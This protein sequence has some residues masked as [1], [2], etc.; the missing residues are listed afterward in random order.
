MRGIDARRVRERLA[1]IGEQVEDLRQL[2]AQ[3]GTALLQDSWKVRGVRYT[4]QTA[5]EAMIDILYHLAAKALSF[6]PAHAREAVDH[7]SQHGLITAEE[8]R[9]FR[10]MIGFRNRLVHPRASTTPGCTRS[11]PIAWRTSIGS[12]TPSCASS[13]APTPERPSPGRGAMRVYASAIWTPI[14]EDR[15]TTPLTLRGLRRLRAHPFAP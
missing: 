11:S 5:I 1:Y 15:S 7:L 6:A 13:P 10:E 9:L 12:A 14:R 8:A 4:L 2:V 3:S